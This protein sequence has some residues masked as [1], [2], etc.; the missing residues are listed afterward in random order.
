MQTT[1]KHQVYGLEPYEEVGCLACG[2]R[3]FEL[4]D[5]FLAENELLIAHARLFRPSCNQVLCLSR[6]TRKQML[7]FL[8]A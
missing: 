1:W 5:T 3:R 6:E 4:V 2:W 7:S 8:L